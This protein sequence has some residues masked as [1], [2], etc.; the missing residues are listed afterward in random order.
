MAAK[1]LGIQDAGFKVINR[2]QLLLN[3]MV[4]AIHIIFIVLVY[5]SSSFKVVISSVINL[6]SSKTFTLL[7]CP[8]ILHARATSNTFFQTTLLNMHNPNIQY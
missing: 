2:F 5:I 8:M 1:V 6:F 3:K 7:T 4:M